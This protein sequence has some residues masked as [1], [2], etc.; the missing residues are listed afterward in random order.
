MPS[1]DLNAPLGK[2]KRKKL[3]KLPV[4][5][6]QI[7]AGVLG[8]FGIAVVAWAIFV[9]DPLGGEPTAVVVT[10]PVTKIPPKPDGDGQQ[11]A[12]HDGAHPKPRPPRRWPH[13]PLSPLPPGAKTITIIDGSSGKHQNVIVPG[14]SSDLAPKA[15]GDQ[16]FLEN[17]RHGAIPKISADGGRPFVVFAH[18]RKLSAEKTDAPR[19]AIIVG[20]LGISAAGTADALAKLPAPVTLAITPYGADLDGI[21]GACPVG[22]SRSAAAGADGT[23]RLSRQRS[24]AAD[25]ADLAHRGPEHRPA[26]LADEPFS[27]LCRNRE[28]YG[29]AL[30]LV[31]TVAGAGAARDRQARADLR[32]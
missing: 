19:I 4:A 31:R 26:A 22:Q 16:R 27:R 10:G 8:L 14:K 2:K 29:R 5:G 18:P 28:L 7:L 23:V 25:V 24:R 3:P 32:R 1:D 21:G 11:H 17:T 15:A 30:H 20:G 13:P 6:P 12:R 9:N